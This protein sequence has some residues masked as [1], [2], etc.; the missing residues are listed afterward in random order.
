MADGQETEIVQQETGTLQDVLDSLNPPVGVEPV[1]E[2]EGEPEAP[3]TPEAKREAPADE[4]EE[5]EGADAEEVSDEL[6]EDEE[7]DEETGEEDEEEESEQEGEGFAVTVGELEIELD[8]KE[9]ADAI[10]DLQKEADIGAELLAHREDLESRVRSLKADADQLAIMEDELRADPVGYLSEKI[11]PDLRAAV[12]E[13]LLL[14]DVVWSKLEDKLEEW[15][16]YDSERKVAAER[17]RADRAEFKNQLEE[18]RAQARQGRENAW[19]LRDKIKEMGNKLP[20]RTKLVWERAALSRLSDHVRQAERSGKAIKRI[21]PED[22]AR[23]LA[24]EIEAFGVN[25]GKAPAEPSGRKPA[26]DA[27]EKFRAKTRKRKKISSTAPVG[28]GAGPA[29]R[30]QYKDM[31]LGD[32]L[33][34]LSR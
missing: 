29:R 16:E 30:E 9:A 17:R 14:D 3:E 1:S 27:G 13:D 23:V 34:S 31:S 5:V 32:A 22:L 10:R 19:E 28:A 18:R 33:D 26:K 24:D 2:A 12:A 6:A 25:A 20:D 11:S 8:S 4:G 7:A 21:D 15:R